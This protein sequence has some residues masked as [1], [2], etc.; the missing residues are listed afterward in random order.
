MPILVNFHDAIACHC[1]VP[2]LLDVFE[3]V[4]T[5]TIRHHDAQVAIIRLEVF[6]QIIVF[7]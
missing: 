4:S 1:P 5:L 2:E 3:Q 6:L 7:C